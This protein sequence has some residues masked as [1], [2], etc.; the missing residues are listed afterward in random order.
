MLIIIYVCVYMDD[1]CVNVDSETFISNLN[2][3]L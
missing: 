1:V 3:L 2:E